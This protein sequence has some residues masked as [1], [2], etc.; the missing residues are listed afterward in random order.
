M[1]PETLGAVLALLLLV[2][3]SLAFAAIRE[4][5]EPSEEASTFREVSEA[6]FIGLAC[7]LGTLGV[8]WFAGALAGGEGFPDP[9]RWIRNG[10]G[11]VASHL[12]TVAWF[13]GVWAVLSTGIGA[14]VAWRLYKSKGGRIEQRTNTW[15]ELVRGKKVVPPRSIPMLYI[16]LTTGAEYI[17]TLDFYDVRGPLADRSLVLGHPLQVRE[18]GNDH[19]E[20][21]PP[22]GPWFRLL[23]PAP[24]IES[25]RVRY[26][27]RPLTDNE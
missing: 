11:Y 2:G 17:G 7:S 18:P 26:R 23:I 5:Y 20:V 14:L 22:D 27:P 12:G 24:A 1:I 9:G 21:M 15:F 6:A 19:F 10:S 4:M 25:M 3:P 16:R 13:V 8:L